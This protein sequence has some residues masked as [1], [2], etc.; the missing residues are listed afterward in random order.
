MAPSRA[1]A[2]FPTSRSAWQASQIVA[3]GIFSSYVEFAY[4]IAGV[5]NSPLFFLVH[6]VAVAAGNLQVLMIQACSQKLC[7][8]CT[9]LA[10]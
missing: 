8:R 10:Q 5:I 2:H 9:A 4:L 1:D 7:A 6:S 3:F